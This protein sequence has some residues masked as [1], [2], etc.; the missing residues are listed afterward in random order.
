MASRDI[1]PNYEP[2]EEEEGEIITG[3]INIGQAQNY[4]EG[5]GKSFNGFDNLV[6]AGDKEALIK[7]LRSLKQHI[8]KT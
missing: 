5:L 6:P 1:D 8:T 2:R 3:P 7:T 4:A